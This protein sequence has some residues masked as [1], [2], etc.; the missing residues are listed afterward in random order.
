MFHHLRKFPLLLLGLGL[1]CLLNSCPQPAPADPNAQP[2]QV[3]SGPE[4]PIVDGHN[5]LIQKYNFGAE[6]KQIS[7]SLPDTIGPAPD[8]PVSTIPKRQRWVLLR[9]SKGDLRVLIHREWAPYAADRFIELVEAGYYDGA[10]WFVVTDSIAQCG[11][12]ADPEIGQKYGGKP[13][14]REP[15]LGSN[16][17][18]TIALVQRD[19]DSRT[20]Q[21]FINLTDNPQLDGTGAD[22]YFLPFAE[23]MQGMDVAAELQKTGNPP[24]GFAEQ[25]ASK[26]IFAFRQK[27]PEGDIIEKAVMMD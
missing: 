20:E 15:M 6:S 2:Q 17:A 26:G 19:P 4:M 8:V 24:A 3:A 11:I 7:D 14:P 10:P 22:D 1:P 13:I 9:T 21:F 23:V 12:P 18:G 5:K 16:T 25:L 27:Y